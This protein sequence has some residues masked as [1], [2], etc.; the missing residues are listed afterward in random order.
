MISVLCVALLSYTSFPPSQS[1]SELTKA[2]EE[3]AFVVF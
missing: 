1:M 3:T 2:K